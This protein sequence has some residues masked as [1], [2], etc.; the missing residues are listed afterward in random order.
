MTAA[1]WPRAGAGS[2]VAEG[3]A[4]RAWRRF[5]ADRAAML[6][7]AIVV[8]LLLF[9]I[10]G[11][12][13]A[14][15]DPDA[16]D[17][18][19]ARDRFG[20]P[21]GPSAAHWLGT[22]PIFRDLF[23]RLAHGA[24]VSLATAIAATAVTTALGALVG[25]TAGMTHG[26]RFRAVDALLMRLVDVLLALPFLLFVTAIG[27]V[28]GRADVGTILLVLGLV[29]W[30][31]TARLVRS[32]T[33][34]VRELDFVA[35]ARAL[36]AGP[37]RIVVKHVLPNVTGTLIVVASSSVA[38]MILA[39]AV[40]SYLTVGIE[41]P[42]A[43]WGR[44]LH[45]GERYLGT[46]LSL[47]AI[48]GIAILLAVL[49]WNRVGEG[50]RDAL[51]P[52]AG[53]APRRASRRPPVDVLIVGAALL[54][55]S[56][57]RPNAMAPPIGGGPE[58]APPRRGGVL[59]V[60]TFLNVRTLDPALAYDQVTRPIEELLYARLVT[61]DAT[62]KLVPELA[63]EVRASPDARSYT[64]ELRQDVRFHDGSR[65]SAADVKRSLERLLHPKSPTP[66]ASMYDG[67]KG[68]AAFHT[69]KAAQLEGVRVLGEHT[70]A[71]D[72]EQPDATFLPRMT[73][74][75]A[76]PVCASAG[77]FADA[78]SPSPPC[79][80]GPFRVESWDPDRS[81]R[82]ARHDGYFVPGRPYLDGVEWFVNVPS[83][84]QRYRFER[85][86][87][88]YARDLTG[89]DGALYRASEAWAGRGRWVVNP[90]VTAIF[91]NTELPPFTSRAVRRAVSL[92]IDPSVMERASSEVIATDRILPPSIPGPPR[93][94]TM[95]RHD[96]A[97]ALAEMERAG[98]AY[99]P[100]TGRGGYPLP[101]DYLVVP[102]SLDQVSAE[103][104]QQ[105]LAKIGLRV[106]L[107]LVTYAT[108]LAESQ[109][110]RAIAMG[111]AGWGADFP[112]PSN[113]F[114]PV[115]STAAIQDD[116]SEN[117]AFFSNAELDGVLARAHAE[118]DQAKRFSYY[119]RAEEIIRDEAP[120]VPTFVSRT[121]ELWHPYLRGYEEHAVIASRFN[122][123][124]LDRGGAGEG[125]VG[126]LGLPGGL[127]G[128][129]GGHGA[130]GVRG[131]AF[132][133]VA[134]RGA[135]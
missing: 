37:L 14:R 59:R 50:L 45:E 96:L 72:L 127:G 116:G 86:E 4:G 15:H 64:F 128:G 28:V 35:A 122:D 81:L 30:T 123:V 16:S 125:A 118:T 109:R 73:L 75:F 82:L 120:W 94:A 77:L 85:G 71:I 8:G 115:F 42:Q 92:A 7:L 1:P 98:Y 32:K 13:V 104:W 110:R 79:G 129:L 19:L 12:L 11:P 62:G 20:A 97:A 48:P 135:R 66:A 36:G 70:V 31:G 108:Y 68:F 9:A 130:R 51:E 10:V 6:G 38:Q 63:R 49:G 44:M 39:E 119:A 76:A 100:A 17:F 89:T 134:T 101:I 52:R 33:L 113:F 47:I 90:A 56:F 27:V 99:D 67:I 46:R 2:L 121:Y 102:D 29:G 107:R 111:K 84:T 65:F 112:D 133:R 5:R 18:T 53:A 60:A 69:G 41:P 61:F 117:T 87:L 126:G 34:V 106:R 83:T 21:P 22:D 95:R 103:V 132:A 58:G 43:T 78:H 54:L 26:T 124:W 57:A 40:L 93:D 114:E 91:L 24:R 55:L 25:V 80:T 88:D 74:A 23:A 3:G 131:G 105:Q